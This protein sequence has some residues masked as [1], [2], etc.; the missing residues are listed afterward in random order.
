MHAR[1]IWCVVGHHPPQ[2]YR[3]HSSHF[4]DV[5]IVPGESRA[6]HF[7]FVVIPLAIYSEGEINISL[8]ILK[9]TCAS[10]PPTLW[11]EQ[12]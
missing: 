10:S 4:L 7:H 3:V 1:D 12:L 2:G 11:Y 9:L 8:K 6:F 5:L